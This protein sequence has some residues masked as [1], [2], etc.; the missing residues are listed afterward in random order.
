MF[1]LKRFFIREWRYEAHCIFEMFP[2]EARSFVKPMT[3]SQEARYCRHVVTATVKINW[4]LTFWPFMA[5]NPLT[6]FDII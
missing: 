6:D 4:K 1:S 3:E 5:E 2:D